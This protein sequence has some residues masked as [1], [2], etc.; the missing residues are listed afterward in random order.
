MQGLFPGLVYY[1]TFWYRPNERSVRVA[2]ILASATLAGAFGGAIAYGVGH[3][4]QVRGLSGWRWLFILEGMPSVVSALF[5][6]FLLPDYP[7]TA[8]WLSAEE[9][10]LAAHR[11]AQQGSKGS[12]ASMTWEDAKSTL[13]EW[14][15][16]CH[17]IV[18]SSLG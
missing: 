4:N 12:S 1:L 7:E 8:S 6:W 5:V 16:W 17:Y 10:D 18:S 2:A 15:L 3:M 11:L 13:L 9:K 14:R